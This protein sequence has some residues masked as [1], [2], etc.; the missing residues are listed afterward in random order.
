MDQ[1]LRQTLG[2]FDFV[3]PLYKWLH[4]I[5]SC[6]KHVVLGEPTSFLGHIYLGCT[7][8]ECQTSEDGVE[9]DRNLFESRISAGATEICKKKKTHV[10]TVTCGLTTWK[11]MRR[12][13]FESVKMRLE[14]SH[15]CHIF[16]IRVETTTR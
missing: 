3:Y 4:E 7:Q 14:F 9:N 16:V 8:L 5:L 6:G 15:Q 10:K 12:N 1:S 11:V 2:S 13:T